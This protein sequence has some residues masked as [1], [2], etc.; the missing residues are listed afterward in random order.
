MA[1]ETFCGA[2]KSGAVE[3]SHDIL[4]LNRFDCDA[5]GQVIVQSAASRGS[6]GVLRCG[7]RTTPPASA[8]EKELHIGRQTR[9]PPVKPRGP[10]M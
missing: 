5:F 1:A 10:N 6:E 4:H 9:M 8:T 2:A 3:L 7:S